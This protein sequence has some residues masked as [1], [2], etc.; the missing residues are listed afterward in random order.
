MDIQSQTWVDRF[1]RYLTTERRASPHTTSNYQR[2][3]AALV[4]YCD[5]EGLKHWSEVLVPQVRRF[6]R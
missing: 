2:D 1:H 4:E 6:A 5:R 3:I